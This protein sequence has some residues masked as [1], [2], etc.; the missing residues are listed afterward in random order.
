MALEFIHR[1]A[2]GKHRFYPANRMATVVVELVDKGKGIKVCLNEGELELL[3]SGGF[4]IKVID[5]NHGGLSK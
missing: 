3:R 1:Y 5:E 2:Y 4:N